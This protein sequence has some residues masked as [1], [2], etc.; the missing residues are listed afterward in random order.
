MCTFC[1]PEWIRSEGFQHVE[2]KTC[3][4][5]FGIISFFTAEGELSEADM[6]II[7]VGDVDEI[8]R[9]TKMVSTQVESDV[10]RES[11][12]GHVSRRQGH[13]VA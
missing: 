9:N 11:A 2:N 5:R 12:A 8:V 6:L 3:P 7:V 13:R 1:S 4:A 10:S